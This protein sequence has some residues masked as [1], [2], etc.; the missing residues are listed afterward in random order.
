MLA[1][2]NLLNAG[3]H[4]LTLIAQDFTGATWF[5]VLPMVLTSV[6]SALLWWGRQQAKGILKGA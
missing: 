5:V 3:G 2:Y 1:L 6:I 4:L